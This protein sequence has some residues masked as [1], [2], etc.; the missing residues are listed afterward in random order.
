[1]RFRN[2]FLHVNV[3]ILSFLFGIT[4]SLLIHSGK[5]SFKYFDHNSIKLPVNKDLT[6]F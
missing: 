6:D 2:D 1:M 3:Q 4:V 5:Y